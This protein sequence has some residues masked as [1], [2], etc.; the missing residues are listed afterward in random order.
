[1]SSSSTFADI[2]RLVRPHRVA[3]MGASDRP[4]SL[5]YSTYNNV[6]NN[7]VIAGGAVP[8]NPRY[9]TVLGDRCYPRVSD[10]PGDPVDVAII[11]L[12]AERVL[13][14]VK[15]CAAARVRHLVVLS[16]GFSETGAAGRTQQ[17]EMVRLARA[18]GMRVYGPNSPGL[19][20]IADRVLLSM[21]PVAG[22]DVTSGPIGLVTQGGGIGRAL[23]QWMDRG[24]GIGL[25]CSPGNEADLDIADFVHH[26][27]EDERIRVI[28]AVVEGFSEGRKFLDV[29]RRAREAGKPIVILKIGRSEYG[30]KTAASHT[31]SIAGNDAVASAV[32]AQYGVVRVD[33]VD[34]LGETLQLFSRALTVTD[35]DVTRPCVY[36][37]SGGTASLAADLV[38]NAGLKLATFEPDTLAALTARAPAFG[39]VDNPVDLTTK[40]FTDGELNRAVFRLICDDPNVGS[41]LFA[42]PADYEEDTVAVSRDAAEIARSTG[43]MLIPVW[44]SPR[45]GGGYQVLQA[46]G[47]TPIDSVQRAVNALR[48]FAEWRDSAVTTGAAD[49]SGQ[50]TEAAPGTPTSERALAYDQSK[51]LLSAAGV[52]TPLE[53]FV[54]SADEAAEAAEWIGGPIVMKLIAPGLIHKTEVGGVRLGIRGGARAAAAFEDMA[55]PERLA[56][57]GLTADGIFV[58]EMLADGLDLLVSA[59]GDEVFGPVLTIGAGGVAAEI[60]RDVAHLAIPF[61]DGELLRALRSLRLWPHLAGFRGR[62]ACDL[63]VLARAARAVAEVYASEAA[64]IAEI[65]VNPLRV[66]VDQDGTSCVALDIVAMRRL[67]TPVSAAIAPMETGLPFQKNVCKNEFKIGGRAAASRR[68]RRERGMKASQAV[69]EVLRREGVEQVFCFPANKMIDTAAEVGIRPIVGRQERSVINMAD[70]YSRISNGERIGVAMVQH[71]PGAEHAFGGIAQA[72]ADSVPLLLLPNG[73]T[74]PEL[75]LRTTFDAVEAYRPIT[76]WAARITTPQAVHEQLRRAFQLMRSGRPGPVVLELP[77]DVAEEEAGDAVLGYTP[78]ARYR[79]AADPRDVERAVGLLLDAERPLIRAGQG[80][81]W[82]GAT[83]ALVEFA[84][85]LN[86]PVATTF[87]GKSAFPEDHPLSIGSGGTAIS[88]GIQ[89]FVPDAD[90]ILSVGASLITTLGSFQLPPGKTIIQATNDPDDLAQQYPIACGVVGDAELVLQQLTEEL[91]RQLKS[92]KAA[93]AGR[94]TRAEVAEVAARTAAEWGPLF[95]SDEVPISPLRVFSELSRAVDPART[96]ITHD[97]GYPRDHLAPH[98]VSTRPRGYLGWGNSTPLGSSLGLALGAKVAAPDKLS[99]CVLGDAAFGQCGLE[100]ETAVRNKIPVLVILVNNAEMTGYGDHQRIAEERFGLKT[101]AGRY[102]E[103]GSA[104]GA[105]ATRVTSPDEVAASIRQ[106]IA[107]A[108]AGAVV[109]LEFITAP[110]RHRIASA[111]VFAS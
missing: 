33:D 81:L 38:G 66:V 14:A 84:E 99:V 41:V 92:R 6:R 59:H 85:L 22:S 45:R 75:G 51:K 42:M 56:P 18:S 107:R 15:D 80:V 47:L 91:R 100:L 40:V 55:S 98:Y 83:N 43:T 57:F 82:A 109:L 61:D 25:W 35:R 97:S 39:F 5:G 9:E 67:P 26:M 60:D 68:C 13:D 24:L 104:L 76:K 94:D 3:V 11:L 30:Q 46:A 8:V 106:G 17:E 37:F 19:A 62:P 89:A 44:M 20:N 10:V 101:L 77:L 65:E 95:D 7:S 50:D 87:V 64:S 54:T 90:L 21:S 32:F 49:V 103:I 34:E 63:A 70:A 4:G 96:V 110:L 27:V 23:M 86:A 2:S 93:S 58:Q 105:E 16:S 1:M 29:A 69:A 73:N 36:S 74:R 102:T 48:R 88:P 111:V 53:A 72:Y 71:G 28:G 108:E 79:S 52:R 31:A 78:S 12:S